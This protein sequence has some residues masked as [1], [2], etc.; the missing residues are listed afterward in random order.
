MWRPEQIADVA[1]DGLR[2][3]A[4]ALDLEQAVRGIDSLSEVEFHPLL[5]GAL[6]AAGWGVWCERGYPGKVGGAGKRPKRAERERCDLVLTEG[7]AGLVDPVV[8][9][10]AGDEIEGTLFADA[11]R[12]TGFQPVTSAHGLEGRATGAGTPR[13][14][15]P[16]DA[17][18]LEVKLVGQFC[19]TGGVPGPNRAY[20]SELTRLP[21]GDIVKLARD[22][23]IRD[24]GLLLILFTADRDT[25]DHDLGV[26]VNRCLDRGLPVQSPSVAR[27][28]ITDRIGNSLCTVALVKALSVGLEKLNMA[29]G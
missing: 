8:E 26:F 7:G 11:L 14:T 15:L 2:A 22:G 6:A 18:W 1:A 20:A 28:G 25:A 10:K 27:F 9:A 4:A 23:V 12:G 3:H 21:A 17:F 29:E 24:A 19:Y 13:L 16:E 5:A